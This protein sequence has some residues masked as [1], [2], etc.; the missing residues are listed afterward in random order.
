[1]KPNFKWDKSTLYAAFIIMLA[2]ISRLCLIVFSQA[3]AGDTATYIKFAENILR[4]C[5]L[6]HSD[7]SS[8]D[9]KLTSG[10]YFP[11][12]PAFIAAVWLV[13]GKSVYAVLIAQLVCY[14]M[15]LN[16]LLIALLRLT[17]SNKI[18]FV[19][20]FFLAVSPLQIGW[21]RFI[22]TEPLAIATSTWFLAELIISMAY[23]KLRVFHLA[24]ALIASIYIRPDT[25]FILIGAFLISF[26]IYDF[27][28]AIRQF[29]IVL[30]LTSIP[31]SGWLIRNYSIGH[32]LISMSTGGQAPPGYGMW[33]NTWVVNE[34]ERSD[35]AFPVWLANYSKINIHKSKYLSA[36]ESSKAQLLI[37]SLFKFDGQKFPENIDKQFNELALKKLQNRG[38]S[39]PIQI[40]SE[41]IIWLLINPFSSWGMPLEIKNVDR[42]EVIKA[43]KSFELTKVNQLLS[44]HKTVIYGKVASF[45]YRFFLFLIFFYLAIIVIFIPNSKAINS[46]SVEV[47]VIILASSI[48]LAARLF[49]FV[50]ICHLES[51]Y[52]VVLVPWI[53]CCCLFWIVNML[54]NKPT[55][56][57]K[58]EKL[59]EISLPTSH[60]PLKAIKFQ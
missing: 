42:S 60:M 47:S 53:E 7:P 29:L 10:G 58:P 5:G 6:S 41:R 23:R 14:L 15:A 44:A 18:M 16:W 35:M 37:S 22:L 31:V 39:I 30:L 19:V 21:Y 46:L 52:L 17:N 9:C 45:T 26:Y 55:R 3:E 13:F 54:S 20:G 28:K 24:L 43:I 1:M 57:L 49:F 36:D 27:K 32:P 11:G 12:Y 33:L 56:L 51:R 2:G 38:I 59:G 40:Y 34:Y 4:G 8:S 48:L 50:F 25:V